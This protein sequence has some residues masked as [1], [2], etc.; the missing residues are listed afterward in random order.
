MP[1]VGDLYVKAPLES[2]Y[3]TAWQLS[4]ES[5]RHAVETGEIPDP[6]AE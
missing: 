1:L 6:A 3:Q 4:P 5:Y 2:T